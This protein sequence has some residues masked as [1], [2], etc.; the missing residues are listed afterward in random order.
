L[1]DFVQ[2]LTLKLILN[3]GE[4]LSIKALVSSVVFAMVGVLLLAIAYLAVER[5]TPENTWREIVENKNVALAI[6]VA[7]FILG[8]ASII[9]AAIH[10]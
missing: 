2:L 5:I 9:S 4:F 1:F 7:A 8:L 3:M 10:G 6:V